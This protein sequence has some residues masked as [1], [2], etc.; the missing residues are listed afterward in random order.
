MKGQRSVE[1]Q[2]FVVAFVMLLISNLCMMASLLVS[3]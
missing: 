1:D 2:L 3:W